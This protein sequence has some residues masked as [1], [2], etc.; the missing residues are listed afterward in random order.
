MQQAVDSQIASFKVDMQ[1]VQNYQNLNAN[2]PLAVRLTAYLDVLLVFSSMFERVLEKFES[3]KFANFNILS[4]SE[5]LSQVMTNII[6]L[7]AN[8]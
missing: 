2:D 4:R 6:G 5:A 7:T 1:N 8:P 3:N